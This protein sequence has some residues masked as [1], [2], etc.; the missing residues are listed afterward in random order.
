MGV[1]VGNSSLISTAGRYKHRSTVVSR[2]PRHLSGHY[3]AI[4]AETLQFLRKLS[5]PSF[6]SYRMKFTSA[7]SRLTSHVFEIHGSEASLKTVSLYADHLEGHGVC[8]ATGGNTT[9]CGVG[10]LYIICKT[11]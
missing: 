10:L 5:Q 7:A 6:V 8:V 3:S 11:T 4:A 2:D 9:N 1:L